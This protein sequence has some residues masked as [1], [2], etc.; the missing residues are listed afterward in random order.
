MVQQLKI[1]LE[2]RTKIAQLEVK[3]QAGFDTG[4]PLN[5]LEGLVAEYESL[6]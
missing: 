1:V 6:M 4:Q 3:L 5:E 2:N